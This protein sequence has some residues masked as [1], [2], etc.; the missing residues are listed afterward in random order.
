MIN[1]EKLI[2]SDQQA[3]QRFAEGKLSGYSFQQHFKGRSNPARC[4]VRNYGTLYARRL[5]RKALRRRGVN[6]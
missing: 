5:A 1:W 3:V 2:T 4:A 6:V